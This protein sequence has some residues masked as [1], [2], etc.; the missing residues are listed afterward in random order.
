[1]DQKNHVLDV[2]K[3]R[4][5]RFGYKK[6]T[7]DEISSDAKISKK[8]LYELFTDKEDL[9]V[10]LFIREALS[11]R[12][13]LFTKIKDMDDPR[14][15]LIR[16]SGVIG[17]NF[18]EQHFMVK[19]LKDNGALYTPYLK[20][21]FLEQT[22]EETIRIIS[23]IIKDGIRKHL[24]RNID[25]KIVGYMIFKLFQA[26]TYARTS[27]LEGDEINRKAN[28]KV[29]MDFIMRALAR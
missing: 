14:E 2:A 1:M 21:S 6:T 18:N 10:S 16:L 24:F 5:D 9:F 12:E 19:V 27:T 20:K 15:K 11:A 8:T 25:P 28:I 26:F 17:D 13:Y 23:E 22:E 3:L 4:F 7:M 29:L